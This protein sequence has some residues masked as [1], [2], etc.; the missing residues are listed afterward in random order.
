MKL[1]LDTNIVIYFLNGDKRLL[2]LLDGMEVH[3]SFITELELLSYPDI[4]DQERVGIEAFL[5]D[6]MIHNISREIKEKTIE[7]RKAHKLK[8]PDC[9]IAAT[10]ILENISL[11]SADKAFNRVEELSFIDFEV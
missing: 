2:S 3:L 1:L 11:F 7:L 5:K 10:A 8:L 9:I 4:S 6:S